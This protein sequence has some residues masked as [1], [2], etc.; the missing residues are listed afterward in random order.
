LRF[1]EE[2]PEIAGVQAL[3][4]SHDPECFY[5]GKELEVDRTGESAIPLHQRPLRLR[6]LLP[7]EYH[8]TGNR[9]YRCRE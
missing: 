7:A 2:P 4:Q 6:L 1:R 3:G 5:G 8:E 9:E